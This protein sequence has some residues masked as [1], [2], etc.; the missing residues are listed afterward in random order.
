MFLTLMNLIIQYPNIIPQLLS[1]NS[2]NKFHCTVVNLKE[3]PINKGRLTK[4]KLFT[5]ILEEILSSQNIFNQ[6]SKN[7][8]ANRNDNDATEVISLLY[9]SGIYSEQNLT[10]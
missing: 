9:T 5:L 3:S 8:S 4:F 1:L 6:L 7:I 10:K 2:I